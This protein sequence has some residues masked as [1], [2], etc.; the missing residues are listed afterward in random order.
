MTGRTDPVRVDRWLWAVRLFKTRTAATNACNKGHVRVGDD[1]AKPARKVRP[2]DRIFVR[3]RNGTVVWTGEFEVLR[4]LEKRVGAPIAVECYEDHSPPPP[5]NPHK[6]GHAD[7][8]DPDGFEA[9]VAVRERGQGRPTKRERREM[10]RFR[11]K[12]R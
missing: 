4:T 3:R 8:F 2:G 9:P 12:R 7:I 11:G 1:T 6:T 5:P 10:E